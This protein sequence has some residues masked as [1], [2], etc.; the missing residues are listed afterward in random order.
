[1]ST[2]PEPIARG[3]AMLHAELWVEGDPDAIMRDSRCLDH[4]EGTSKPV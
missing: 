2:A 4:A 3:D 1:M